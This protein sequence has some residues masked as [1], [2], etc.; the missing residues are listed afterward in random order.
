M[1][2]KVAIASQDKQTV[3]GHVGMCNHF[4]IYE[5]DEQGN[6]DKFSLDLK[7]NQILRYSFHEDPSLNPENPLFEVDYLFANSVGQGAVDNLAARKVQAFAIEEQNPD[8]AIKKLIE[9]QLEVYAEESKGS[10]CGCNCGGH[11]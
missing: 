10:G 6:Y 7:E 4:F 9:G 3:S 2:T 5:I 8:E 1:N 11:N